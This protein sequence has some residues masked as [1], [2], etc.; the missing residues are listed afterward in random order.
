MATPPVCPA[1]QGLLQGHSKP[2][3]DIA[4]A[5]QLLRDN[6]ENLTSSRQYKEVLNRLV[7]LYDALVSGCKCRGR[8]HSKALTHQNIQ[9]RQNADLLTERS[10]LE[11]ET[12]IAKS[13]LA[14]AEANADALEEALRRK[15]TLNAGRSGG[16][17]ELQQGGFLAAP[18]N[19]DQR[20]PKDDAASENSAKERSLPFWKRRKSPAPPSQPSPP[21]SFSR[22]VSPEPIAPI[23]LHP[24]TFASMMNDNRSSTSSSATSV[25]SSNLNSTSS[26]DTLRSQLQSLANTHSSAVTRLQQTS[27][28]FESLRMEHANLQQKYST[29]LHDHE[30]LQQA[31]ANLKNELEALSV[32]LFEEANQMVA[33]ERKAR[34]AEVATLEEEL[35]KLKTQLEEKHLASAAPLKDPDSESN[36]TPPL[37]QAEPPSLSLQAPSQTQPSLAATSPTSPAEES[38]S[39]IDTARNWFSSA[40]GRTRMPD[41]A[42]TITAPPSAPSQTEESPI[43]ELKTEE[44]EMEGDSLGELKRSSAQDDLSRSASSSRTDSSRVPSSFLGSDRAVSDARASDT[45]SH[46]SRLFNQVDSPSQLNRSHFSSDTPSVTPSPE[47]SVRNLK[48]K[49]STTSSSSAPPGRRSKL[50]DTHHSAMPSTSSLRSL[51][52]VDA[53]QDRM[54]AEAR[55]IQQQY[56]LEQEEEEEEEQASLPPLRNAYPRDES[57]S[58]LPSIDS[59]RSV[60]TIEWDDDAPPLRSTSP[61]QQQQEDVDEEPIEVEEKRTSIPSRRKSLVSL[62]TRNG[63]LNQNE[64]FRSIASNPNSRFSARLEGLAIFEDRNAEQEPPVPSPVKTSYNRS[65][66]N[67]SISSISSAQMSDSEDQAIARVVDGRLSGRSSR[68]S[69]ASST[70][71]RSRTESPPLTPLPRQS[72]PMSKSLSSSSSELKRSASSSRSFATSSS[73]ASNFDDT[74]SQMPKPPVDLASLR[75]QS[76]RVERSSIPLSQSSNSLRSARSMTSMEARSG[77]QADRW[78]QASSRLTSSSS[79]HSLVSDAPEVPPLPS[80]QSD[81]DTTPTLDSVETFTSSGRSTPQ[82]SGPIASTSNSNGISSRPRN[83][84]DKWQAEAGKK[85]ADGNSQVWSRAGRRQQEQRRIEQGYRRSVRSPDS[86]HTAPGSLKRDNSSLDTLMQSSQYFFCPLNISHL[87][88]ADDITWA[89]ADDLEF[90]EDFNAR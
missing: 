49:S 32:D 65:A 3:P 43:D 1:C 35:H 55:A 77:H 52:S 14:L 6:V 34:A 51:S 20:S 24:P 7:T 22:T 47:V 62:A 13:N 2:A 15:P 45:S 8:V 54:L 41:P 56:K 19:S 30:E 42:S 10:D 71:G 50:A 31:H 23:P 83:F 89:V 75:S 16:T 38:R 88:P 9:S 66:H 70:R 72:T 5:R 53:W 68:R 33:S 76:H 4:F 25:L 90:E 21:S 18:F 36:E 87:L 26:V 28:S 85:V 39:P 61:L 82:R 79:N 69:A 29:I 40:I 60:E 63:Q 44:E 48:L 12:K 57:F 11:T 73:H 59:D 80:R 67:T 46:P 37:P 78:S 27:E 81:L 17:P 84:M 64:L 58:S 86:F 74:L